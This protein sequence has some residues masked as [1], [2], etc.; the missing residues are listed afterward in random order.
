MHDEY[1]TRAYARHNVIECTWTLVSYPRTQKDR[2]KQGDIHNT[3]TYARTH[4]HTHTHTHTQAYTCART[5]A[6]RRDAS[7]HTHACTRYLPSD[8]FQYTHSE[9]VYVHSGGVTTAFRVHLQRHVL[10]SPY[11]YHHKR[12]SIHAHM[13]VFMFAQLWGR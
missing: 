11:T 5:G 10:R 2:N 3:H 6:Q 9:G 7:R 13:C 1:K 12:R 8:H 4:T